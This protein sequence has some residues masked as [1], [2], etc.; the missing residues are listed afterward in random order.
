MRRNWMAVLLGG[1]CLLALPGC[2]DD[3]AGPPEPVP[4]VLT[5]N[6][7]TPNADDRAVLVRVTGPGEAAAVTA[8]AGQT[9]FSRPTAAGFNAAVFGDLAAG[10]LLRFSVPDVNQAGAYQATVV[11]VVDPS[12]QLRPSLAGYGATVVR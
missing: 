8:A 12:D 11:E 1:A 9:L 5:V 7:A 3:P 6:L 2:G 4:G 10:P